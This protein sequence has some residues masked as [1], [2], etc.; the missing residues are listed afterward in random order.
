MINK[1]T[2]EQ[3]AKM[4]E[5]VKRGLEIGLDTRPL[6]PEAVTKAINLVYKCGG[7]PEPKEII[8]VKSPEELCKI[9]KKLLGKD[10]S[11]YSS[12]CYGQHDINWV[13]FYKFFKDECAVEGLEN[14]EGLYATA[15]ELGWFLPMSDVCY[16]SEKPLEVHMKAGVLHNDKGPSVR[17]SDGFELYTLNGI[18]MTKAYVMEDLDV[19]TVMREENVDVR[20]ELLR[21]LGLE[22]F[23][24]DTGGTVLD[25]FNVELNGKA[26]NYTLLEINLGTATAPVTAR[27]LKMDNPSIDAMHVEG[28]EDTCNTVQE[29]LAWRNGMDTWT[30]PLALT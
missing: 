13:I 23:I 19:Q 26:V 25:S 5:Y 21:R 30:A 15:Q 28:V 1:L 2:P 11:I 22:R 20:R 12:L 8:L 24:K 6:N 17:Y 29:A 16:V 18:P 7:Q 4:P 14:I 3:E 27:V 9:G 10:F